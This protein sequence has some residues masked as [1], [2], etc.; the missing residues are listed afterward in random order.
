ME[1]RH[2]GKYGLVV[3]R[4]CLDTMNFGMV[5]DEPE[6]FAILDKAF[7]SGINMIDT[8]D[9]YGGPQSPDMIKGFGISEE[10]IGHWL[11]KTG[12]RNEIVLATKVYQPMGT[13]PNDRHLSAYHI[14]NAC[15]DSLR[16]LQTDHIDI[17]F[18]HHIDRFTPWEEIWQAMETLIRQG[19]ILY[20]GSSNFAGW[21]IAAGQGSAKNSRLVG[22]VAEQSVYNLARRSVN[23]R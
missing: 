10:I 15:E 12:K 21:H 16:S 9:V 13:G 3:S 20:V 1:Y 23:L 4:L 17:Y 11:K 6:S 2:L 19:K 18:I 7:S 22:L 8:A 14:K 5:T